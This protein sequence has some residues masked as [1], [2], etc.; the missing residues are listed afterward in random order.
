MEKERQVLIVFPHPDDEAFGVAGTIAMHINSGTP[1]T[2]ACLTL[3]RD[4]EKPWKSPI[5]Y[6]RIIAKDSKSGNG[7]CGKG[8][9]AD[10][11]SFDGLPR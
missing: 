2:Y 5:C 4:G 11:P 9:G 10:G 1:V 7:S 6:K 8:I 3:R